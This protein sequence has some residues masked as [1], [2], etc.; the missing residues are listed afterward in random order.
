MEADLC[1]ETTDR[2]AETIPGVDDRRVVHGGSSVE[3]E[4]L[5]AERVEHVVRRG[6][7]KFLASRTQ[8]Q[9]A[10]LAVGERA[11]GVSQI[12]RFMCR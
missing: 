11:L 8:M 2:K 6:A 10:A 9:Y 5:V 7:Q 12:Q 3:G 1:V 4:H